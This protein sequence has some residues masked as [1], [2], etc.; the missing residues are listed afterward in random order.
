MAE[1]GVYHPLFSGAK[2][3]L[4][5]APCAVDA[6]VLSRGNSAWWGSDGSGQDLGV[7][8]PGSAVS[9][10]TRHWLKLCLSCPSADLC[11]SLHLPLAKGGAPLVALHLAPP[12]DGHLA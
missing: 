2:I 6:C 5:L 11:P 8:G 9:P 7:L 10:H 1:W 3:V 12:E 4:P